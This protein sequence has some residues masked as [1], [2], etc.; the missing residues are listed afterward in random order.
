MEARLSGLDQPARK[1]GK[2]AL[3]PLPMGTA[4][5][6]ASVDHRSRRAALE[7]VDAFPALEGRQDAVVSLLARVLREQDRASRTDELLRRFSPSVRM[8]VERKIS[9]TR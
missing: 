3:D 5:Y 2:A 6:D 8:H 9:P 4:T 1:T 7:L